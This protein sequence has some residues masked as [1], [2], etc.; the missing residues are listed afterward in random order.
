MY[1]D[2]AVTGTDTEKR[3][4]FNR[5]LSD[6]R[7]GKIDR[8]L[9]KSISRFARNT[10]DCLVVLREL[11]GLG[12]AVHFEKENIGTDTLTTEFMVSVYSSLAQEESVSISQNQRMSYQR[13]MERGELIRGLLWCLICCLN[14]TSIPKGAPKNLQIAY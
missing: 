1:A 9:V 3:D 10:R 14:Y 4:D 7:R 8:I 12:V 5:M 2:E 11:S 13:R 6:C